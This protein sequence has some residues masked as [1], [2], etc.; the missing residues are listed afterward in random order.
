VKATAAR[1][2]SEGGY[3]QCGELRHGSGGGKESS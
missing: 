3:E 2:C 1:R